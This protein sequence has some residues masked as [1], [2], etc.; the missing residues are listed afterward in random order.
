MP[1]YFG[2]IP[3]FGTDSSDQYGIYNAFVVS[4]G[5]FISSFCGGIICDKFENYNGKKNYMIKSY[6][7]M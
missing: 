1:K 2:S 4:I 6:V 3:A 7:C 5:G